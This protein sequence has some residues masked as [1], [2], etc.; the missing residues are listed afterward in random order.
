MALGCK[1]KPVFE[2]NL[3][4][5]NIF[6]LGKRKLIFKKCVGRGYVN[7]QEGIS[8]PTC[9]ISIFRSVTKHIQESTFSPPN[10]GPKLQDRDIHLAWREVSHVNHM[11]FQPGTLGVF[12]TWNWKPIAAAQLSDSSCRSLDG[13][14]PLWRAPPS[15][16][17]I[18]LFHQAETTD[19]NH[20]N[21]HPVS[22]FTKLIKSNLFV[23]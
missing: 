3:Q 10:F 9:C 19:L 4:G 15:Q 5:I 16:T 22:I 8:I 12:D 18:S 17:I 20:F 14:K 7:F 13:L 6:H 1:F 23:W 11:P 2:S 21:Q